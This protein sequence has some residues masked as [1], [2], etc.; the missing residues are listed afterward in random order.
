M[1]YGPILLSALLLGSGP[2]LAQTPVET[3]VLRPGTR[4][5]A[6]VD[7]GKPLRF[8]GVLLAAGADSLR[9]QTAGL[10]AVS[11]GVPFPR[12]PA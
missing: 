11:P 6:T 10:V 1:R 12:G 2:A 3:L 5:R 8:V 4:L 7:S 9:V